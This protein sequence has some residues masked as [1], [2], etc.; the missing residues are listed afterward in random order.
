MKKVF[1]VLLVALLVSVLAGAG[2]FQDGTRTFFVQG[3]NVSGSST[4]LDGKPDANVTIQSPKP[5]AY[6]EDTVVLE[7]TIETHIERIWDFTGTLFDPWFR[8]GCVLDYDLDAVV[9]AFTDGDWH[10]ALRSGVP[11]NNV[12]AVLSR[13][14]GG[15]VGN[16]TLEG[17]AQGWHNVTVW[18]RVERNYLSFGAY[19]GTVFSTV[20]FNVDL[21]P[22]SISILSPEP[23]RYEESNVSLVCS[24]NE[25]TSV[26]R[27]S[28]DGQGNVTLAGNT[29]LTGLSDGDHNVTVYGVDKFGNPGTSEIREFT[30]EV[31][32]FEPF[33]DTLLVAAVVVAAVV[34]CSVLLVYFIKFKKRRAP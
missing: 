6:S 17:L 15:Y 26:L 10:D 30:V 7:F 28:L 32:E 21:T 22:L 24:I 27:Y 1:A 25:A 20:S 16:A 13:F 12:G 23:R 9:A 11:L 4:I 31:P 18:V 14:G 2:L 29:T 8:W 3:E 5:K 33:A 34:A 19:N